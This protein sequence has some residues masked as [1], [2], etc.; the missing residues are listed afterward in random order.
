MKKGKFL[1]LVLL[2]HLPCF[3]QYPSCV[4]TNTYSPSNSDRVF[5]WKGIPTTEISTGFGG[6]STTCL[7]AR[8]EIVNESSGNFLVPATSNPF[9]I[10]AGPGNPGGDFYLPSG[11]IGTNVPFQMNANQ[12]HVHGVSDGGVMGSSYPTFIQA[13]ST[14]NPN[15]AASYNPAVLAF[16]SIA[17]NMCTGMQ[18]PYRQ[19]LENVALDANGYATVGLSMY[20]GQEGTAVDRISVSNATATGLDWCGNYPA[21]GDGLMLDSFTVTHSSNSLNPRGPGSCADN[22]TPGTVTAVQCTAN[23]GPLA[24]T[25]ACVITISGGSFPTAVPSYEAVINHVTGAPVVDGTWNVGAVSNATSMSGNWTDARWSTL[26]LFS[27][28]GSTQIGI[29]VPGSS[30]ASCTNPTS[31]CGALTTV[32]LYTVDMIDVTGRFC[33]RWNERIH[34]GGRRSWLSKG[35]NQSRS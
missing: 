18:G 7:D 8:G 33:T 16:G 2:L 12:Y 30:S 28:G 23:T 29:T 15:S 31:P 21:C 10:L 32:Q 19:T 1:L 26:S 34:R 25:S 11:G 17:G 6:N 14:F 20:S 24:G 27:T 4:L 5:V 22:T 3:A 13:T 9:L 35:T